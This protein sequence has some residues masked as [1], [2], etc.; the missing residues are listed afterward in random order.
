MS[1]LIK[2]MEMPENCFECPCCRHD[3]VDGIKMEQCNLTLDLFDANYFER[4]NSRA[5]NCPLTEV[6][7]PHGRLIDK[8]KLKRELFVNFMGERIP[9]YDCDNF[10][11][12]LT[13]INLNSILSEQPTVIEAEE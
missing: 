8:T 10:P 3:S 5:Q 4:W 12:T 11:T 7:T 1:V 9:F 6:K 13:Y 2:G